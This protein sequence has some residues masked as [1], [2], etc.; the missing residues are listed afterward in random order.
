MKKHIYLGLVAAAAFSAPTQGSAPHLAINSGQFS[1]GISGYVPVICRTS[2]QANMVSPHG[3]QVSL[4][5][6]NEFC[7]SP[8]GYAVHADYSSSLVGAKIIV[9][10][11]DIL[12][13]NDGSA[14]VVQSDRAAIA[15]RD[16]S[17][18]LPESVEGGSISFRIAPL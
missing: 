4:G 15:N 6:L 8:N 12:L 13:G 11:R 2:V 7:N 17:L 10:G 3:G 18:D 16:L 5:T 9:D 14:E 1:I